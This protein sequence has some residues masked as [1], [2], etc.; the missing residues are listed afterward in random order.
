MDVILRATKLV[1]VLCLCGSAVE[2]FLSW[3]IQRKKEIQCVSAVLCGP[4][5]TVT[6]N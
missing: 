5:I 1:G 4:Y 3:L 2:N 6:D